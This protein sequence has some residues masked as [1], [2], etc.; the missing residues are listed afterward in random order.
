MSPVGLALYPVVAVS[1]IPARDGLHA[2]SGEQRLTGVH[3]QGSALAESVL[4]GLAANDPP[5]LFVTELQSRLRSNAADSVPL[6]DALRRL[7]QDGAVLVTSPPVPDPHLAG[8]DLRI[9]ALVPRDL[10]PADA[11][12]AASRATEMVWGRWLREFLASHRCQ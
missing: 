10:S 8:F 12:L 6:E 7:E 2:E 3:V 9:V 5:A 4:A 11:T 1:A